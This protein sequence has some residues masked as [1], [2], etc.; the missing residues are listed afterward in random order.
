MDAQERINLLV[1]EAFAREGIEFALPTQTLHVA[2]PSPTR[3]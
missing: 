1:Y 2:Q 3:P